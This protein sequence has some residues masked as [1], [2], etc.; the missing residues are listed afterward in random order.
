MWPLVEQSLAQLLSR[1]VFPSLRGVPAYDKLLGKNG[2]PDP[3]LCAAAAK[4]ILNSTDLKSG[5]RELGS[6]EAPAVREWTQPLCRAVSPRNNPNGYWWF[7]EELVQRWGRKYPPGTAN[8]KE[9]ILASIRPMLAVSFDWNDFTDLRIMRPNGSVPVITGQG[10]HKP[11]Y[12]PSDA[13]HAEASNVVFIG[14]Y[15]QV[16]V[17]FV[18]A[19]LTSDYSF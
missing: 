2:Q 5:I 11:I 9:E 14:G 15:T 3:A 19:R 18:N 10:L 8:R 12:S 6:R 13:R 4:A 17:P 1:K 16:F 7:D